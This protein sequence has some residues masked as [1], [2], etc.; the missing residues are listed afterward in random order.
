MKAIIPAGGRGSRVSVI[1]PNNLPKILMTY[2]G[3]P[4]IEH[5]LERVTFADQVILTIKQSQHALLSRYIKGRCIGSRIK[6][7]IEPDG[8]LGFGGGVRAAEPSVSDDT[9]IVMASDGIFDVPQR[10]PNKTTLFTT[11]VDDPENGGVVE[12][13]IDNHVKRII[14]KPDSPAT[15]RIMAGAFYVHNPSLFWKCLHAIMDSDSR[16]RGEYQL[17]TIIQSMIDS[18]EPIAY[19]DIPCVRQVHI[20]Y[21]KHEV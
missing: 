4:L 19:Q 10:M 11:L 16:E 1:N 21:I 20:T 5:I 3:I 15:N 17:T 2:G 7:V 6:L 18:G 12:V 8:Q 13:D 9:F 14:E